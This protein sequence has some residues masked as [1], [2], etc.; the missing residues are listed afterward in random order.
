MS[1]SQVQHKAFTVFR[2]YYIRRGT[3]KGFFVGWSKTWVRG[4]GVDVMFP[5]NS[6]LIDYIE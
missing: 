2:F 5:I 4:K 6:V 3:I 1:N